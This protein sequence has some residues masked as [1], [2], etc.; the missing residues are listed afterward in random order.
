MNLSAMY[1]VNKLNGFTIYSEFT[2]KE[3]CTLNAVYSNLR[4]QCI[5][6]PLRRHKMPGVDNSFIKKKMGKEKNKKHS[7]DR[8]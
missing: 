8:E 6:I 5:F 7:A 1:N 3:S 2:K 4:K